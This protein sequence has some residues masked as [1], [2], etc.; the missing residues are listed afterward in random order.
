LPKLKLAVPSITSGTGV[1][2]VPVRVMACGELAA[3]SVI[4]TLAVRAVA[5]EGVN[6]TLIVQLPPGATEALQLL[7][8][9]KSPAFV[10]VT[11]M[12]EIERAAVPVFCRVTDSGALGVLTAVFGKA[13][14]VGF[15]ETSGLP[16]PLPVI[17]CVCGEPWPESIICMLA[18]KDPVVAGVNV[19]ATAHDR[20]TPKVGPQ[21]FEEIV[22]YV[23]FVPTM[24]MLEIDKLAVPRF[25]TVV[26]KGDEVV[27]TP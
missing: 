7:F 17:N 10:P 12:L 22:K 3:L 16:V 2:P 21:V 26:T 4:V 9:E 18:L 27:P 13:S 11:E 14:D 5:A 8:C 23:G 6:V 24:V 20:F 25:R 1:K 19:I 15:S